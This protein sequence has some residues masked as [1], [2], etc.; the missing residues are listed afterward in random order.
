MVPIISS[1]VIGRDHRPSRRRAFSL[2][3]TYV[4]AMATTYAIA[5]TVTGYFGAELNLQMKLQSPWVL[6]MIAALFVL[7]A[8]AMFDVYEL[9][10]PSSLQSRLHGVSQQQQGGSF[11]ALPLSVLFQA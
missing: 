5:G 8:L 3:L 6:S 4:L 2:S 1:I 10:L 9:R 11:S 7:F